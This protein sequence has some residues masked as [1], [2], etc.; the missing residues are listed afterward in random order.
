MANKLMTSLALEGE[1]TD[2]GLAALSDSSDSMAQEL[3]KMLIEKSEENLSLKDIWSDYR[4]KE[5]QVEMNLGKS[6]SEPEIISETI[7]KDEIIEPIPQIKR[8]SSE[9]ERI[10]DRVVKVQFIEYIGKR[11]KKVTHIEVREADLDEM[12]LKSEKPIQVQY[13]LF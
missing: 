11:K 7:S 3:A 9:I 2:K 1:L 6:I 4:K 13:S 8:A 5:V 10:G 12:L